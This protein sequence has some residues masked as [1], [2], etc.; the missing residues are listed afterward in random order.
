MHAELGRLAS[1]AGGDL[2]GLVVAVTHIKPTPDATRQIHEQVAA[3]PGLGARFIF[4]AQ[5][6]LL[7]L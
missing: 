1:A 7:E 2:G 6:R 5:G 4:P 3:L